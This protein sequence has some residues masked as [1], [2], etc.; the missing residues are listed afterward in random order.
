MDENMTVQELIDELK[1]VAPNTMVAVG[2]GGE[3]RILRSSELNVS[4]IIDEDYVEYDPCLVIS[5]WE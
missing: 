3:H 1:K 2:R 4:G 5:T